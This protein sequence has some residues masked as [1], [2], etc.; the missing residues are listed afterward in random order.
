[1]GRRAPH[2]NSEQSTSVSSK[3]VISQQK[4]KEQEGERGWRSAEKQQKRENFSSDSLADAEVD[5]MHI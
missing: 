2:C 3:S 4:T 5:I 1:M